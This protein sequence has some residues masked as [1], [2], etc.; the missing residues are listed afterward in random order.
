MIM[1][2]GIYKVHLISHQT[3]QCANL[4][5]WYQENRH[6]H[7]GSTIVYCVLCSAACVVLSWL[8][9]HLATQ[10]HRDKNLFTSI[11]VSNSVNPFPFY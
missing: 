11:S 5:L 7:F 3:S 6:N 8:W 1:I 2:S 10:A 4:L 9:M